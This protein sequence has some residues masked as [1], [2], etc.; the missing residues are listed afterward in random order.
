MFH[1]ADAVKLDSIYRAAGGYSEGKDPTSRIEVKVKRREFLKTVGYG[2][3]GA[4]LAGCGT[5]PLLGSSGSRPNLVFILVDDLGW[6][7]LG[8]QG[9]EYYETPRIDRLAKEGMV[10]TSAYANAPNCAPTRAC[11][12]SGQYTPRH[13]VYTVNSA[14]RG[15]SRNRRLIPVENIKTLDPDVTTIAEALRPAGYRSAAIGKWHLGRDPETGPLGQGFDLNVGGNHLGH[16]KSY[17]SPYKNPELDDGPEGESLTERLTDEA[18]RFIDDNRQNPFFLYLSHYAVHTPIQARPEV[19]ARYSAK[20]G[21][22]GHDDPKYAAM[23]E[24]VDRSVGRIMD[25]LDDLGLSENTVVVFFSDNGPHGAISSAAPLRG[26]KG[27]LYEG[28]IREPMIV[29]WPGR[30]DPGSRCDTPVIGIDFFPTFLDLA[31]APRP[32]GHI[33]DGE[34]LVPLIDGGG[35]LPREAVF[36]HFP[37]YLE[38]YRGMK[39]HWRTTPAGAVRQGDWKLIEFFEDRRVELYNLKDDIGETNDLS[40]AQVEKTEE[41]RDFLHRWQR[42]VNAPIPTELNPEFG[43]DKK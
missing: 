37:A 13:G 14:A 34:S 33:L 8:F 25:R 23:I 39:G 35:E 32:D 24:S 15:K 18:L 20:K 36:W 16:P 4:A 17:F 3:A 29:R 21:V 28:G 41:M 42:E 10:F 12:F 7:D 9:S 22:G 38:A 27:M 19:A 31:G 1:S 26:S 6:T 5:L 30:I 2:A 40:A 43:K 11:I